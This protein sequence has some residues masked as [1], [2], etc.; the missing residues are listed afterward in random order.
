LSDHDQD[1][2]EVVNLLA[3]QMDAPTPGDFINGNERLAKILAR[4]PD[5][6]E[7]VKAYRKRMQEHEGRKH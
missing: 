6:A 7:K 2:H 4:R 5:L 3:G 1:E